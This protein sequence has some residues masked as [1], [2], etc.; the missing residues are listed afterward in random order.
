MLGVGY[1]VCSVVFQYQ[2]VRQGNV[3]SLTF[4]VARIVGEQQA[5]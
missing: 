3:V 1:V 4:S 2:C 5:G